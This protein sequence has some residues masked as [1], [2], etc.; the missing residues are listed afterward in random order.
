MLEGLA[1]GEDGAVSAQA[2]KFDDQE[3]EKEMHK[4]NAKRSRAKEEHDREMQKRMRKQK[5]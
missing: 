3:R 1:V 5:G 2:C 4:P